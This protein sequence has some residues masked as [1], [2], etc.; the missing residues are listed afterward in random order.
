MQVNTLSPVWNELWK[1]KNVPSIA[2]LHVRVMDKDDGTITDDIVGE[3]NT[4]VTQG[5]KEFAIE[6][7]SLR[8]KR[9][10]FWLQVPHITF[11]ILR[12]M[13]IPT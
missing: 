9:G 7:P 2:N 5:A 10:T 4:T 8:R 12:T 3:F 6:S 11:M 13:L 1:V